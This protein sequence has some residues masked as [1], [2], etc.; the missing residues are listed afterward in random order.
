[1]DLI[2]RIKRSHAV[3]QLGV[4]R[5]LDIRNDL[6][7]QFLRRFN[8]WTDL[9]FWRDTT[10]PYKTSYICI[11]FVC[12]SLTHN[13]SISRA[14]LSSPTPNQRVHRHWP[15]T[16]NNHNDVPTN[17]GSPPPF[18]IRHGHLPPS[19]KRHHYLHLC[20]PRRL[21]HVLP[22][23]P[24]F[25]RVHLCCL[26]DGSHQRRLRLHYHDKLLQLVEHSCRFRRPWN[27]CTVHRMLLGR[28]VRWRLS[29]L[30]EWEGWRWD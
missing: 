24:R 19:P 21:R 3:V 14:I 20:Q 29:H 13:F 11:V 2:I 15:T 9:R 7:S 16:T 26:R 4:N 1:M 10:I 5:H 17:H 12:A 27:L 23:R 28:H 30:R 25:G 22:R 8:G 6:S 18:N